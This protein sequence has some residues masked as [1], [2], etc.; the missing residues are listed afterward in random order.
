M[1]R[2]IEV[3]K[4]MSTISDIQSVA[5][6]M[7]TVASAKLSRT[8]ERAA[9]MRVYADRMRRVLERQQRYLAHIEIPLEYVS[10]YFVTRGEPQR[11]MLVHL[12]GD[13]GMCGNYNVVINRL[14]LDAIEG[15]HERGIDVDVVTRGAKGEAYLRKRTGSPLVDTAT[16]PRSGVTDEVVDD[17]FDVACTAFETGE[18]D[19]VWCTYTRYYA[20]VK[21]EPSLVRLLP[22]MPQGGREDAGPIAAAETERWSYEPRFSDI[23]LQLARTFAR[24]Q[25]E[26]VLLES[27]ASE[28]GARMITMEEATERA[29][30]MLHECRVLYNRLRR[31]FITTDL[32]GVL[33]AS[34]MRRAQEAE[35]REEMQSHA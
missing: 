12:S 32:I 17:L 2:L 31:E 11:I 19:E 7:A 1:Q 28:Q 14:A 23:V 26:D 15:W 5:R 16:W 20:P 13:H 27:Y 18:V 9:G 22:I 33:F 29:G 3:K 4:R 25:F 8:R 34:R 24:M 6:T 35:D 30:K 21:R 10:H